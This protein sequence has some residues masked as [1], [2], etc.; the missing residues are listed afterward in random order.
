[1]GLV[2]ETIEKVVTGT[3]LEKPARWLYSELTSIGRPRARQSVKYD[4]LTVRIMASVLGE[5]SNCVD[6]GAHKGSMLLHM[7]ELAPKG[8]IYAFEPLP[9]LAAQLR[10]RWGQS[11]N[12]H[13]FEIALSDEPGTRTF[14]HVTNSP[15]KSG[16]RR[17]AHVSGTSKVVE[18]TVK[19]D[20][21]DDIVPEDLKIDFIKVDVEGAQ[22]EAFRGATR[23]LT[24]DRPF[25]VFEHGMM[26]EESYGTTSDMVYD[27]LVDQC[28]LNISLL[29]DWLTG[30]KPLTREEFNGH[31]GKHAAS[32]FCFLAHPT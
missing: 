17:M 27:L 23:I 18:I 7:A 6:M 14:S 9:A 8:T 32:H 22:L 1:M 5:H 31:V 21:L 15:G 19:V 11:P 24:R 29:A 12:V 28:S 25:V 3:P 2:A 16:F 30:K 26:A 4:K 10:R 13:I 20:R